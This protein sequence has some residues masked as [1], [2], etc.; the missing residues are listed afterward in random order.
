MKGKPQKESERKGGGSRE[1]ERA[2]ERERERAKMAEGAIPLQGLTEERSATDRGR[3]E[4]EETNAAGGCSD[5]SCRL[6]PH[7]S[8]HIADLHAVQAVK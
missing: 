3:I 6:A 2:R 5:H 1:R 4:G 8:K 7:Q